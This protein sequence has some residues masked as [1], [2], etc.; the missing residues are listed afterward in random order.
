MTFPLSFSLL[1]RE[2]RRLATSG[3][4]EEPEA[5]VPLLLIIIVAV[6]R[7]GASLRTAAAPREMRSTIARYRSIPVENATGNSRDERDLSV[8]LFLS[9]SVSLSFSLGLRYAN[10]RNVSATRVGE[11][12]RRNAPTGPDDEGQC[13]VNPGCASRRLTTRG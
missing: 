2:T 9:L 12:A 7:V 11:T 10:R 13:Q 5:R 6:S 8:C 1:G 4:W 3:K